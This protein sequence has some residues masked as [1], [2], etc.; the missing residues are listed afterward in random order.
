M[1]PRSAAWLIP[2]A[3]LGFSA[4]TSSPDNPAA[5]GV[6]RA[7]ADDD[8][9]DV[10][11]ANVTALE[12]GRARPGFFLDADAQITNAGS[13]DISIARAAFSATPPFEISSDCPD[14][15][16]PGASCIV[17]IDVTPTAIGDLTGTLTI[18]SSA[19]TVSISLH[20]AGAFLL[21]LTRFNIGDGEVV[22]DPPGIDCRFLDGSCEALFTTPVTLTP[23]PP[24]GGSFVGWL[25]ACGDGGPLCVVQVPN[26]GEDDIVNVSAMFKSPPPPS[27]QVTVTFAGA[28]TG[29]VVIVDDINPSATTRCD[30]SPCV[31]DIP[32]GD[33]VTLWGFASSQFGGW[34]GDCVAT[35]H[36]C[37]LGDA[38]A[39]RAAVVTFNRDPGEVVSFLPP[40]IAPHGVAFAPD[41]G[42]YVSTLDVHK[43]RLDGTVEWANP[44]IA[45]DLA[46][47]AAGNVY[48]ANAGTTVFSLSPTGAA[49]W[50]KTVPNLASAFD[51]LQSRVQVSRDGTIIAVRTTDGVRVL[52]GDGNDRFA[53]TGLTVDG[54]ALAPDGTIAIGVPATAVNRRDIRRWTRDGTPLP[55]IP[56]VPSNFDVSLAF[57]AGDAVCALTVGAGVQTVSRTRADRVQVFRSS[58]LTGFSSQDPIA[59]IGVDSDGTIAIARSTEP[60]GLGNG[61]HI[62]AFSPTGVKTFALEK[63]APAQPQSS[64]ISFDGVQ[65]A[66]FAV[67]RASRRIA[68]VGVYAQRYGWIEVLELPAAP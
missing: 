52:D 67:D 66:G 7:L 9:G 40:G 37:D 49:R 1:T 22:S 60:S 42:L 51:R 43:L 41:G 8:P 24:P 5:P 31:A 39:D 3:L 36:D 62:D 63:R 11:V 13:A 68:V 27:H 56:S 38:T 61:L 29:Q 33:H 45:F 47:D 4:C 54:F 53:L 20:A 19:N 28:S 44:T 34:T 14:S 10:L 23:I 17:R 32:I 26:P 65:I 64:P 15:L 12:L 6:P 57:D 2:V 50:T 35:T 25:P 59:S 21:E 18:P 46:S 48:A 55:T 30:T 16:A 58:A